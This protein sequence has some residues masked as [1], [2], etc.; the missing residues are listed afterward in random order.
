MTTTSTNRS[1][2]R[3]VV[4]G[5]DGAGA[6]WEI[7]YCATPVDALAV[8]DSLAPSRGVHYM[9]WDEQDPEAGY[10]YD[11]DA[12]LVERWLA[13]RHAEEVRRILFKRY[14]FAPGPEAVAAVAAEI[15]KR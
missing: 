11:L 15:P 3:Y 2:F 1:D 4:S 14:G 10:F 5:V 9:A 8:L 6:P 7:A 13:E 12:E